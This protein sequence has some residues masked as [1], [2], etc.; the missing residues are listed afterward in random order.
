MKLLFW[1]LLISNVLLGTWLYQL[2]PV[3]AEPLKKKIPEF[4][5]SLALMNEVELKPEVALAV[6]DAPVVERNVAECFTIGPYKKEPDAEQVKSAL[7]DLNASPVIRQREESE[8]WGYRV[9]I[10]PQ[11]N[12]ADAQELARS[13]QASGVSD[14]YIILSGE[15]KNGVSLGHFKSHQHAKR[16][17][18]RV[19]QLGFDS[20]LDVIEKN[21]DLFWVDYQVL[22]NSANDV[23]LKVASFVAEGGVSK[24][25]RSCVK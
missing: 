17:L 19:G 6:V 24:L 10:K 18:S 4:E 20:E 7:L 22:D 11:D 9:Y 1:V 21:Y 13:L 14:Y 12:Y 15:D 5:Q 25:S 16:R 2:P 23:D 3:S 8:R